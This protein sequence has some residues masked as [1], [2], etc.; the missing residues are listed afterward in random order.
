MPNVRAHARPRRSE[1][2]AWT[3]RAAPC[4]ASL[5]DVLAG[6]I[7]YAHSSDLYTQRVAEGRKD[8]A[9]IAWRAKRVPDLELIT[10]LRDVTKI[11]DSLTWH[12]YPGG[13]AGVTP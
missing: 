7:K 1:A 9:K 13:A 11:A 2:E 5:P 8:A 3:S 4:W 6:A 12:L 10:C